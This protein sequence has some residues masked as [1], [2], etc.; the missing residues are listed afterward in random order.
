MA[1]IQVDTLL[2]PLKLAGRFQTTIIVSFSAS[3]ASWGRRRMFIK[4]RVSR[5]W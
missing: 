4:K 2:V 3:S 1:K 5:G